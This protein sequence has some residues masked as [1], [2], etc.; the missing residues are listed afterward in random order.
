[1][2]S[3]KA[4]NIP[5]ET[6]D[7]F[8]DTRPVVSPAPYA[9]NGK[10]KPLKKKKRLDKKVDDYFVSEFVVYS[11]CS[12]FLPYNVMLTCIGRSTRHNSSLEMA[13]FLSDTWQYYPN[14]DH[15][16]EFGGCMVCRCLLYLQIVSLQRTQVTL[17]PHRRSHT[18][19]IP[20]DNFDPVLLT[21]LGFL[22]GLA[23]SFRSTTAYERYNEGR[24]YWS[25]LTLTTQNLARVIWVH[26]REREGEE[27]KEDLLAK[28]FVLS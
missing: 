7:P 26:A 9:A 4:D 15:P 20:I 27:G 10:G 2:Q 23:L 16:N 12:G 6:I 1:M 21:V 8:S 5:M 28:M 17:A 3:T 14:H 19:M 18:N 25:Q 24:K 13:I 22:V 11:D